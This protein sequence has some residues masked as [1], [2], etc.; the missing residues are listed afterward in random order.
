M[1]KIKIGSARK[2]NGQYIITPEYADIE[3]TYGTFFKDSEAYENDWDAPCYAEEACFDDS[4]MTDRYW[5]HASLLLECG[6]NEKLCDVMF[7]ELAWQCPDTWL[8]ELDEEDYAQFW[9]W[10]KVGSQAF[11]WL[12]EWWDYGFY[13]VIR[14]EDCLEDYNPDTV[15]WLRR[16]DPDC[17]GEYGELGFGIY[18]KQIL[19]VSFFRRKSDIIIASLSQMQKYGGMIQLENHLIGSM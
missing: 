10:L 16:A 5:T 15:V 2:V 7:A 19:L 11:W 6:Y 8:N 17:P 18:L 12:N 4:P 3:S 13:E 1:Q 14:I 9:S